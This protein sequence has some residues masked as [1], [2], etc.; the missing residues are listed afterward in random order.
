MCYH[1]PPI[2][3]ISPTNVP[4]SWVS[5]WH[6]RLPALP[7]FPD[8]GPATYPRWHLV[9]WTWP[10][11]APDRSPQGTGPHAQEYNLVHFALKFVCLRQDERE[12]RNKE[13]NISLYI[14]YIGYQARQWLNKLLFQCCLKYMNNVVKS[15]YHNSHLPLYSLT[16]QSTFFLNSGSLLGL[17]ILGKHK[18]EHNHHW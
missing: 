4:W 11:G 5:Q 8:L 3:P 14:V 12:R 1:Y 13:W 17:R 7:A 16:I 2:P 15:T 10:R 18:I 9:Q 6:W